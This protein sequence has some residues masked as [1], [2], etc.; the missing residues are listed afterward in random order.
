MGAGLAVSNAPVQ[1]AFRNPLV[2]ESILGVSAGALVEANLRHADL[3]FTLLNGADLTNPDVIVVRDATQKLTSCA[4][5]DGIESTRS[6]T[7]KSMRA[8]RAFFAGVHA[9]RTSR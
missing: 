3:S 1:G 2:S 7:G 8:P 5:P 4:I 6:R 9:A